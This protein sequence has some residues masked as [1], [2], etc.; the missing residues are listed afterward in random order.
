MSTNLVSAAIICMSSV[1][2]ALPR[3]KSI[4]LGLLYP[5]TSQRSLEDM[6]VLFNRDYQAHESLESACQSFRNEDE[7]NTINENPPS[8]KAIQR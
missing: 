5:E 6:E 3:L 7:V 1:Q 8:I 4:T 2:V